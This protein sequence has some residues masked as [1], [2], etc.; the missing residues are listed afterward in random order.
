VVID[1]VA[2]DQLREYIGCIA[3]LYKPNA[4]HNCKC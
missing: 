3:A 4:F 1:P 2:E